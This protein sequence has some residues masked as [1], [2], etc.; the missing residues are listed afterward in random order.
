MNSLDYIG[1]Q[2]QINLHQNYSKIE[3]LSTIINQDRATPQEITQAMIQELSAKNPSLKITFDTLIF[4]FEKKTKITSSAFVDALTK[5]ISDHPPSE[6]SKLNK[7]NYNVIIFENCEFDLNFWDAW[8]QQ[9]KSFKDM[10]FELTSLIF[11]FCSFTTDNLIDLISI[12]NSVIKYI[13]IKNQPLQDVESLI[14]CA[15][16]LEELR[17]ENTGITN[18][19]IHN[20]HDKIFIPADSKLKLIIDGR[21]E[22]LQKVPETIDFKN[23][24]NSMFYE[25]YW[26][27]DVLRRS[28]SSEIVYS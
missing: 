14:P 3:S 17:L 20:L 13:S 5:F 27:S 21:E 1:F 15:K 28:N 10:D 18:E 9:L 26:N 4:K 16:N 11:D 19:I 2:K 8:T 22:T 25:S 12:K 23:E 6:F 24:Y 7:R